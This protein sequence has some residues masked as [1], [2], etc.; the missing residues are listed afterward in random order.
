[1]YIKIKVKTDQRFKRIEDNILYELPLKVTDAL[2]GRK[3]LVPTMDGDKEV[4]IPAGVQNGEQLFL[5]GY[6]IHGRR[7]GDQI[8]KIKIEIPRKLSGKA[9]RLVEELAG[10]I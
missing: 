2:L 10:E 1:M 9:R 8:L 5:R 6:G 3:V 7:N 4:E